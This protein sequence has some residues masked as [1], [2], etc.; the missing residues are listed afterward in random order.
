[1]NFSPLVHLVVA[2]S[3][4]CFSVACST[5]SD[6]PA[7]TS[8]SGQAS[9]APVTCPSGSIHPRVCSMV[10]TGD[11]AGTDFDVTNDLSAPCPADYTPDPSEGDGICCVAPSATDI[12]ECAQPYKQCSA[13][14]CDGS[15]VWDFEATQCSDPTW[16]AA[17]AN[18]CGEAATEAAEQCSTETGKALY[19]AMCANA[20]NVVGVPWGDAGLT[21]P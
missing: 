8:S 5:A 3:L 19:P 16:A 1:M 10:L 17:H 7:G 21:G 11:V 15:E 18:E 12:T 2:T 20:A 9:T 14:G 6:D 13:D 4:V